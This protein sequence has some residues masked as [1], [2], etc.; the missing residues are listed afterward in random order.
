MT[1]KRPLHREAFLKRIADRREP[2]D[3]AVIG[4]GSTGMGIAVDAASRGYS[5]VLLERHDFGKG[6]SSRSTK[7]VHGGVRYLQQGNI[8]LVMEALAERGRLR[9]NAPHL[10]HDLEFVVPNYAWWEAPF[11]GIGMKVYDLLAGKYGFGPSQILSL[12]AVLERIPTLSRD[13]LRGGVKYHDGQFDDARLLIDLASTAA[14]YDACLVNYARVVSLGKDGD[15]FVNGLTFRDEEQGTSY[16]LW[17]RCVI[18]ATGPFCDELRSIDDPA[19][20]PIIAPSQGV[21]VVLPREFLPGESAIMVPHTR[22]GRV[23]FAIPWHGHTLIGTTDT[24]IEAATD[25][26]LATSEEI[27]LIFETASN[28]LAKPPTRA[29]VLSVFTGIRPLVKAGNASNTAA[30]SREHTIEISSSGLL[31]IAGGKWTTYRRMAEDA[32][33][34]AVVLGALIER[35]CVTSDLAIHNPG[36]HD[37]D[38]GWFARN[39]MARTVEDVLARRTRLL[40]LNVRR[41]LERA[42]EVA[43][44]LAR[45]L[46]RDEAWQAAQLAAFRDTAN[47][48]RIAS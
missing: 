10:V 26:P 7:L 36:S 28:Y 32:V 19:V 34:H 14:Q 35:P 12:E 25:E 11:Y 47:H 18:N 30:L 44:E 9:A 31:T 23:M 27:D 40:F 21:H 3:I 8:S 24:P 43:R 42:P 1:I 15:G 39:E 37:D 29:D 13:G 20:K 22:D 2:W 45:E 4:G 38:A 46:G 17:A 6:T 41:A 33:D 48:F 16:K 5:V